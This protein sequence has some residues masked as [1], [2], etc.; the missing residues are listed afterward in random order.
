MRKRLCVGQGVTD[1]EAERW[2]LRTVWDLE[3]RGPVRRAL[4]QRKLGWNPKFTRRVADLL[5]AKRLV[6]ILWEDPRQL[7]GRYCLTIEGRRRFWI[8]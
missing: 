5:L 4:V 2:F 3:A 6:R 7:S 1:E 8:T